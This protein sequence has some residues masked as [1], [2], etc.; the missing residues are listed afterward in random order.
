MLTLQD[1]LMGRDAKYPLPDE[2][3]I[4]AAKLL[5][6]VNPLLKSFGQCRKITSGWRP[7]QLNAS[8]PNV[9]S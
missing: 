4:N 8:V 5:D 9:L 6:K 3:V 7:K 2:V 1:Y